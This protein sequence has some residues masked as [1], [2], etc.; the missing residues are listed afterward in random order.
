M[1][2]PAGP[3]GLAARQ[4]ALLAALT[5]DGPLPA[6]FD[7]VRVQA[8]RRAL[9]RKRAAEAAREWPVLAASLGEGW[10]ATFAEHRGGHPPV[11][12]LRDGWEVA[13]SLCERGVLPR[14]AQA[15]LDARESVLRFDGDDRPRL[16]RISSVRRSLGALLRR[17]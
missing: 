10:V 1:T 4:A 17:G 16:R 2:G 6:G 5:V 9:L 7:P 3:D 8:T 13:R 14:A 12:T 15:E 11:G